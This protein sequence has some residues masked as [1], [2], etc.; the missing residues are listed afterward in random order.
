MDVGECYATPVLVGERVYMF[1]RQGDDEVMQALDANS[2]TQIWRTSY[3]APFS[4]LP[5]AEQHGPGPK[6]TPTF[7]GGNLYT[8]GLGG[9]VSAFDAATGTELWQ[10]PEPSVVPLY[11]TAVSPLVDGE[12]VIV[13]VGGDGQG[14]LTAFDAATGEVRW[15]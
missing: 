3:P 15:S 14:A 2:G 13:H 1:T 6:A 8:L 11:G 9:V 5:A 12:L 4:Y 7:A 10:I